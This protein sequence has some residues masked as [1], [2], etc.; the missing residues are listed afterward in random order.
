MPKRSAKHPSDLMTKTER[1][2]CSQQCDEDP[3][4]VEGHTTR[5]AVIAERIKQQA[6]T[7]ADV[8]VTAICLSRLAIGSRHR[9]SNVHL[10]IPLSK[11]RYCPACLQQPADSSCDVDELHRV[12]VLALPGL[13]AISVEL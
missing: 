9:L 5:Y 6:S 1:S 8:Q 7:R 10:N 11:R 2:T 3:A 13:A 4:G 12:I